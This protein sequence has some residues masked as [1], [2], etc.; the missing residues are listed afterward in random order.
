MATTNNNKDDDAA[1][2]RVSLIAEVPSSSA[3]KGTVSSPSTGRP[4][5]HPQEDELP[6]SV[7]TLEQLNDLPKECLSGDKDRP[8]RH[9][10]EDGQVS[11]YALQPMTYAV[12]FILVVELLER[13][14]FYGV[15]YTQTAYLTGS[16]NEDWNADMTAVEASSYVAVS[17]GVAYTTPFLG[18]FLADS[19]LGDFYGLL[20]GSLCFYLP[21]LILIALTTIP[22]LLGTEFNS[23][24]LKVGF[25]GLW[26]VG[27]GI[28]K[29]IVNVFGAKQFHPLLQSS[30]I[31]SYYVSFYMCINI[32]ALVGGVL[33]P[34][35]AQ[36]NVTQAYFLPVAML[37]FAVICFLSGS[38]KYVRSKPKGD[39]CSGKKKKAKKLLP[40][41]DNSNNKKLSLWTVFSISMLIVPFNIAYAQMSTTFIVQGTVMQQVGFIDASC[42]N[43]ADAISVL[44]FG[45]VIG[46]MLYPALAK[47]GI[48]LATT[49]KFAI[50]SMFGV[51]AIGW[52]LL[53][54]Y[55]IHYYFQTTG[56]KVTVM[57]QAPSYIL[58]G[59]GEIFAVSSAYE[60]A[61]SA[62]PPEQ[63]A[64][65]SATNLFCVGGLPNFFCIVLY[66]AC[67]TWFLNSHG[68]ASLHRLEDY[69][70]AHVWKYFLVLFGI[71]I[72]GVILNLSGFVQSFVESVEETA[73]EMVKTPLL[74]KPKRHQRM[75]SWD[76]SDAKKEE[77]SPLLRAKRHQAYLKYGSGPV[78]NRNGSMRAGPALAQQGKKAKKVK[79]KDIARLYNSETALPPVK[80][81]MSPS[82]RPLQAGNLHQIDEAATMTR[83]L[84]N[85]DMA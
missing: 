10:D 75:D 6:T 72:F 21:G 61:F 24:A 23:A 84:S 54:D 28:V 39:L 56:E 51:M 47:R 20:V 81:V 14:C 19:V 9:V 79:R 16:Y 66:R 33:V 48:K 76:F 18:A 45:Y 67:K 34:V 69:A 85:P 40:S 42:M 52:A 43:N 25:I 80:V 58:I 49:H 36:I 70:D 1:A 15:N 30:L 7:T 59:I 77:M 53:V 17:V 13:F 8:L 62:S 63:K 12:M 60:V 32:G 4:P 83:S 78:L 57:W 65:A 71:A 2:I 29:A 41:L 68:I 37:G 46:Q 50:G 64:L 82:G 74:T 38:S 5:I 31:E 22:G 26:P 44:F 35:L 27:T 73:A 11:H 55:I 3:S